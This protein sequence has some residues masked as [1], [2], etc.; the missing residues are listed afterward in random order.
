[1]KI[2]K[3]KKDKGNT[4]KV[5]FDDDTIIDLYDDV[6]V[7]YNLLSNKEM[8]LDLFNEITDYN[9]FLNGYY[10]SI[11]YINKKLR[12]ELEI[13]K[14][15]TKLEIPEKD[16]KS[17]IKLL[18]KDGYLNKDNYVKAYINDK[19][20]LGNDGPVKI[21]KDLIK[22]GYKFED[23][24]NYLYSLDWINK[25]EK[26][27]DKR[28]KNNHNNSINF[29]KMKIVSDLIRLGYEKSD[30]IGVLEQKD[31][32]SDMDILKKEYNKAYIKYSKK[33]KDKELDMKIYTY[34]YGKGFNIEDIKMVIYEN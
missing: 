12:S 32:S 6:I 23:F 34:L 13:D 10:K 4:Y 8:D 1:M 31:F 9:T 33:Y 19:Y 16:R 2:E 3:F 29:L 14:Y 24:N 30:I 15:L 26:S 28:I 25:I 5:Y 22:L 18:Y 7:K 17:I 20:N 11:K 27:I 21:E